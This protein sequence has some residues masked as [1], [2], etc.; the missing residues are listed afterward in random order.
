MHILD[1]VRKLPGEKANIQLSLSNTISFNSASIKQLFVCG[2]GYP[3]I[4][5]RFLLTQQDFILVSTISQPFSD[6][7]PPFLAA[8]WDLISVYFPAVQK[9]ICLGLVIWWKTYSR[10]CFSCHLTHL[11]AYDLE[12]T[13]FRYFFMEMTWEKF[14]WLHLFPS[15]PRFSLF[16]ENIQRSVYNAF[17]SL[18]FAV[19]QFVF[20]VLKERRSFTRRCMC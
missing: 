2:K 18:V 15:F 7:F 20:P 13:Y 8:K 3:V 10:P 12:K 4:S 1:F 16:N 17:Y 9:S 5:E 11:D 14:K 6:R 19:S